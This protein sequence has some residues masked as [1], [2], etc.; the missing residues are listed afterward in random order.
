MRQS[1]LRGQ[2]NF[3]RLS[4]SQRRHIEDRRRRADINQSLLE[5]WP[6]RG[7]DPTA[8]TPSIEKALSDA[9]DRL[10]D[11]RLV[12]SILRKHHMPPLIEI[13]GLGAA[14]QSA[15][16]GIA[17]VRT[18]TAGL[19]VDSAGLVA[20]IKD[21]RTQIKQAHDDLKFEAESLGNGSGSHSDT[22]SETSGT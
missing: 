1:D 8:P 18:E 19:T 16:A 6:L 10:A 21:V 17:T 14:V 7:T 4:P 13:K 15:R 3:A 2:P 20:A 12:R 5:P 9:A 11:E 22:P